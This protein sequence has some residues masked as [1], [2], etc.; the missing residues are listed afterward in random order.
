M[1][2]TLNLK[3]H[4]EERFGKRDEHYVEVLN[5][6]RRFDNATIFRAKRKDSIKEDLMQ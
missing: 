6:K 5:A 4:N 3:G 1:N 2:K